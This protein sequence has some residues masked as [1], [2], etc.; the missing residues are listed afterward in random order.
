VDREQQ[1]LDAEAFELCAQQVRSLSGDDREA[2]DACRCIRRAHRY[3]ADVLVG[4]LERLDEDTRELHL[5]A[6]QQDR[7]GYLRAMYGFHAPLE[8]IFAGDAM[9]ETSRRLAPRLLRELRA[10]GDHAPPVW[11]TDLPDASTIARRI[12]IAYALYGRKRFGALAERL[13]M[14]RA[15]EDD[16]VRAARETVEKRARWITLACRGSARRPSSPDIPAA[17]R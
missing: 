3:A 7:R 5:L 13:L 16:A 14:D 8:E 2:H 12:G 4:R 1:T 11:C 17:A 15:A 6:E 10:L 9:F